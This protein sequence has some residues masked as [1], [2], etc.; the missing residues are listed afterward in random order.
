MIISLLLV[1][2]GL[3]I[4][5]VIASLCV[6]CVRIV[7]HVISE[8]ITLHLL[9]FIIIIYINCFFFLKCL[10]FQKNVYWCTLLQ[11][12]LEYYHKCIIIKICLYSF[13]Q[14]K[15]FSEYVMK[16]CAEDWRSSLY[17]TVQFKSC[18][19][20]TSYLKI[21]KNMLRIMHLHG[22]LMDK[23]KSIQLLK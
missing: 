9:Y 5:P 12:T 11:Y 8:N 3:S 15:L 17:M 21:F 1:D 16:M 13:I 14:R 4:T 6:E 23:T 2:S 10:R 20:A 7:I 19:F 18:N 22:V